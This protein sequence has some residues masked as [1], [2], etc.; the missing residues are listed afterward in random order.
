MSDRSRPMQPP[1]VLS[2]TFAFDSADEM[3]RAATE[4]H[5]P[6]YTRWS[7]PTLDALENQLAV[8]EGAERALVTGSGMAAIHLALLAGAMR[9]GTLLVLREVYGGT[10]ELVETLFRPLGVDV[11]R[12]GLTE[13]YEAARAL[14]AKSM[15]H[16][17]IPTN[18][19]I[20][21]VDLPRLRAAA[22]RDAWISVDATFG[23]PIHVQPLSL[24]ANLVVHSVT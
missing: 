15:V 4:K 24:G 12:A 22:P 21:L 23:T 8:L 3:A 17:E 6:I 14:P 11:V 16:I 7:N 20:R 2:S 10:H 1:V 5:T 19:L 18:P 13:L 9:G